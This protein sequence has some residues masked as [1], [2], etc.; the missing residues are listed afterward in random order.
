MKAD[1]VKIDDPVITD[2]TVKIDDTPVDN[3]NIDNIMKLSQGFLLDRM[4]LEIMTRY[5]LWMKVREDVMVQRVMTLV[6]GQRIF[7]QTNRAEQYQTNF[8]ILL[9]ALLFPE[10]LLFPHWSCFKQ[11]ESVQQ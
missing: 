11:A 2:D 10:G 1:P 8:S 4:R 3:V 6:A 5:E 9:Q 7:R